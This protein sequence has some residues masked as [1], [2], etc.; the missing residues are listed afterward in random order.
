ML[1]K[2]VIVAGTTA[3]DGQCAYRYQCVES[4]SHGLSPT[5]QSLWP[6]VVFWF[7]DEGFLY[8]FREAH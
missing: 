2:C 3:A 6:G 4:S 8:S 7:S 1:S 5:F